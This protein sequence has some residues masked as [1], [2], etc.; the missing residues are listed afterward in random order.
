MERKIYIEKET[1]S[2][3]LE[4]KITIYIEQKDVDKY[5]DLIRSVWPSSR[6]TLGDNKK[7]A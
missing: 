1:S 2:P 6:I 4:E 5:I 7:Y 3:A